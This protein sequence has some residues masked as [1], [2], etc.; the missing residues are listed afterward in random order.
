MATRQESVLR[1][2][3]GPPVVGIGSMLFATLLAVAPLFASLLLRDDVIRE[4]RHLYGAFGAHPPAFG[5]LVFTHT[6]V[7]RWIVI[8]LAAVQVALLVMLTLQR[9]ANARRRYFWVAAPCVLVALAVVVVLY[10]PM[11]SISAPV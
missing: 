7:A 8:A 4:F 1:I 5:V 2:P 6:S 11:V 3:V 10:A 9:T